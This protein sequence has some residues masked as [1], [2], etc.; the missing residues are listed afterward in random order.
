MW[1]LLFW[2]IKSEVGW[3]EEDKERILLSNVREWSITG[4]SVVETPEEDKDGILLCKMCILFI[5][6]DINI[7]L[8]KY[9]MGNN[10][11]KLKLDK[12]IID[13]SIEI[14]DNLEE[15][16]INGEYKIGGNWSET[17]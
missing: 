3:P 17:H 10:K 14:G 16:L 2:I 11:F 12:D 1:W 4:K 7:I 13:N 8:Y 6:H 15:Q 5:I 9:N